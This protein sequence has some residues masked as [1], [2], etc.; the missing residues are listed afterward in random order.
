M[1][2]LSDDQHDWLELYMSIDLHQWRRIFI[3]QESSGMY[4]GDW[5]CI[6]VWNGYSERQRNLEENR[7]FYWPDI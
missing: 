4:V 5:D 6:G 7:Y 1:V 3:G 2:E